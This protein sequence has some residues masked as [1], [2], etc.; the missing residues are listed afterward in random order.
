MPVAVSPVTLQVQSVMYS[1]WISVA[2]I[3]KKHTIPE[4][5][6]FCEDAG[7]PFARVNT[8]SDLFEDPHLNAKGGMVTVTLP[9]GKPVKVPALPIQFGNER[10]GLRMDLPKPG[11][12]TEEVLRELGIAAFASIT[13]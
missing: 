1:G 11:E 8:P 12:H 4:L 5:E 10:P 3:V 13:N 7:L 6:K 9:S 2:S